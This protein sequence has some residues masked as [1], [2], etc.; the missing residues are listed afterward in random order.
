[1]SRLSFAIRTAFTCGVALLQLALLPVAHMLHVGCPHPNH[2]SDH[3]AAA[4]INASPADSLPAQGCDHSSG[5]HSHNSGPHSPH[6]ESD[7]VAPHDYGRCAI[8]QVVLAAPMAC[9]H[10]LQVQSGDLFIISRLPH[11]LEVCE[12]PGCRASGRGPPVL[13]HPPLC[14][15]ATAVCTPEVRCS[16]N[17]FAC[18]NAACPFSPGVSRALQ[19]CSSLAS[20]VS[21]APPRC[22]SVFVIPVWVILY[23]Q[24]TPKYL[25]F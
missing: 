4:L 20:A 25:K 22:P 10:V 8:C 17:G 11:A 14:Y 18:V 12:A 6:H 23:R 9:L 19:H 15:R 21:N 2:Y 3:T 13:V 24:L 16:R 1:M 5:G 7:P